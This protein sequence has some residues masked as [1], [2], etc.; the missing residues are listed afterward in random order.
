M[1]SEEARKIQQQAKNEMYLEDATKEFERIKNFI[2][3]GSLIDHFKQFPREIFYAWDHAQVQYNPKNDGK[4]RCDTYYRL[5][6]HFKGYKG[7]NFSYFQ[8]EYY[9]ECRL[10][11]SSK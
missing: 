7:Y 2:D 1:N 4:T 10:Y 8:S 11:I 6:E 5:S 9:P 3:N